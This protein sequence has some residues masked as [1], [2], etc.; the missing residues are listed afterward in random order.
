MKKAGG[1]LLTGF[2][3]AATGLAQ[4]YTAQGEFVLPAD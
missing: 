2:V 4:Q 3:F 1:V